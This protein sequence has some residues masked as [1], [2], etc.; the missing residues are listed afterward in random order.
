MFRSL[1]QF[2]D[3]M[4]VFL[5]FLKF[6]RRVAAVLQGFCGGAARIAGQSAGRSP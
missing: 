6:H 2:A 4:D 5:K 3:F 1:E